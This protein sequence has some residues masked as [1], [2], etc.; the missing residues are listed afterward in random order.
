MTG[1]IS[2]KIEE[3]LLTKEITSTILKVAHHGSKD[4]SN[5]SFLKTVAP[6][7]AITVS[8]TH[9]DVYKRQVLDLWIWDFLEH[10]QWS[11]KKPYA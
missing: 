8:Y 3:K 6:T 1:D 7:Y 2:Q 11:I 4:S 9:L 10:F 5:I